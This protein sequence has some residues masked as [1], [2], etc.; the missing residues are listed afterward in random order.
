MSNVQNQTTQQYLLHMQIRDTHTGWCSYS[1][2]YGI[3]VTSFLLMSDDGSGPADAEPSDDLHGGPAPVLHDVAAD[4]RPRPTQ[5][6][7]AVHR[8][9]S[10]RLLAHTQEPETRILHLMSTCTCTWFSEICF[11]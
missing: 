11:C 6:R 5:P 4:Q 7:L 8:H 10:G 3:M 2:K 1:I 9:R